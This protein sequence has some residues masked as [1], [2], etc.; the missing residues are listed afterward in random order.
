M[1]NPYQS[2]Q[3]TSAPPTDEAPV[4][5]QAPSLGTDLR[6]VWSW[7]ARSWRALLA[8]ALLLPVATTTALSVLESFV[9]MGVWPG[10]VVGFIVGGLNLAA[11]VRVCL[12]QEQGRAL[13]WA[14]LLPYT[15]RRGPMLLLVLI[16]KQTLISIGMLLLLFPGI[17][18]MGACYTVEGVL[19]LGFKH[20]TEPKA[21]P[22]RVANFLSKQDLVSQIGGAILGAGVA[23]V[24][25]F[26][27]AFWAVL[28]AQLQ[29]S[30]G[31]RI[32]VGIPLVILTSLA[33][34]IDP[35]MGTARLLSVAHARG[36]PTRPYWAVD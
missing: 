4:W 16:L 11:S 27:H 12:D 25:T 18:A 31:V 15:A 17:W 30:D 22:L 29:L 8:L 36:L 33:A 28:A 24:S 1:D 7:Y 20:P 13:E 21:G 14:T 3:T 35:L 19:L 5:Q 9:T 26:I 34:L 6:T 10:A 2:P 23:F 32:L